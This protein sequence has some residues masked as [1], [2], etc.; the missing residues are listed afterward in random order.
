MWTSPR[1]SVA[2]RNTRCRTVAEDEM[3]RLRLQVRAARVA[4]S[5]A[6]LRRRVP[7]DMRAQS[8]KTC[9]LLGWRIMQQ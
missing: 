7:L 8:V 6:V 1:V 5:A 4:A 2:V 3:L 9:M